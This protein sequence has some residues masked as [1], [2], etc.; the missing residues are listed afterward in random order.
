MKKLSAEMQVGLFALGA[1]ILLVYM[2]VKVS[3]GGLF[4]GG[5][6]TVSVVIDSAEGLTKKT[7]VEVAGIQVGFVQDIQLYEGHRAKAQLRLN[8][9]V[10]LGQDAKAQVRTKGFLGETYIE[11][12]PGNFEKGVI[13]NHGQIHA[14]NPYVDLGQI[15]SDVREITGSIKK[16][17]AEDGQGPVTRILNNM[18]VFTA[19][20]SELTVQNQ[21]GIND[22]VSNL[23]QFST[24]LSQVMTDRK[25]DL[26]DTMDRIHNITRKIDEG[27]G[28]VGR[29]IN[30]DEIATNLNEAAQGV[31]DTLGGVNRFQ[32]ELGFHLEYLTKSKEFKN[33]AS[34]VLKPRP[35]KY[36]LIEFIVDPSPSPLRT[37]TTT[38]VTTG[39]ATATVNTDT[40]TVEKNRFLVSAELAKTF[41]NFTLRGG[42]IESRGGVGLDYNFGPLDFQFSA[43]DLRTDAQQRPHLK[44]LGSLNITPN[45]YVVSGL[46]DF[47]S[48]QERWNWFVGAGFRL[49]DNDVRSLLGA[50]S[51]R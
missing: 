32:I 3:E 17:L 38:E 9:E 22:I 1:L 20:L 18:E 11:L 19:K 27:R 2:T 15:A 12:I 28:T 42:L 41:Y 25:E 35:D 8:R 26:K 39:G 30:D 6:Y 14:T 51:L 45:L 21:E 33:Y 48:R 10:K 43:F 49:V 34:I 36:F 47:I 50:A 16:L 13:E 23:R 5:A 31:S 7:P 46:D 4:K 40:R 24:D 37:I 44:L 29:L